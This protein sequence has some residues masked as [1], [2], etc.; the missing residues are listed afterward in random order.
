MPGP[1]SL[2]RKIIGALDVSGGRFLLAWLTSRRASG[3]LGRPAAVQYRNGLWMHRLGTD[4]V[5][6]DS[7]HYACYDADILRWPGEIDR[8]R[9]NTRDFFNGLR[10]SPGPGDTIVDIG[11]GRGEDVLAFSQAV[12]P[13]GKVLAVEAHPLSFRLLKAF[14]EVNGLRNVIPVHAAVMDAPGSVTISDAEVWEANTVSHSA[15]GTPVEAATIDDLCVKYA[16]SK[17]DFLK[18][19]IEGAEKFALP[20]MQATLANVGALCICC[21]DFRADRGH[22]EQYRTRAFVDSFLMGAGFVTNRCESAPHDFLRDHL[23]AER[24]VEAAEPARRQ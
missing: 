21:H 6:P 24:P 2:K 7:A 8:L 5:V 11:A 12:G 3:L 15:T 14:C 17:V 22:G 13:A 23:H 19:N 1:S 10:Y 18:M 20:G 9:A 16:I 4:V